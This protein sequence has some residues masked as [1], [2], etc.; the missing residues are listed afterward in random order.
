MSEK[1][2]LGAK[3]HR[4]DDRD[5]AYPVQLAGPIQDT[6]RWWAMHGPDFR[7]DQ[8]GEGT[9]VGHSFTNELLASP[10]PHTS[11]PNFAT[12]EQAH[13]FA[14]KAYL[15]ASGDPT[16]QAGMYVRTMMD[17]AVSHNY[18]SAYYRCVD[19]AA[20][21]H[22]LL[23]TGPVMFASPWYGS[24]WAEDRELFQATGGELY[25]RVD[26]ATKL[27]GYHCY[28][29]TGIDLDPDVGPPFVRMENSWGPGWM[30]NGTIRITVDD[31][32]ILYD[33]DSY[34]L[35]EKRF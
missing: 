9:C 2:A 25:L 34:T 5:Y 15:E 12:V 4:K 1:H 18:A 20:T 28:L 26:P 31:L 14:R 11:Y 27:V 17:Y 7:I 8:G 35:T 13:Q 19:V 23:T 29:L 33:G 3:P 10:R 21:N 6:E 32:A 30:K 22:A 24:M 16:Y